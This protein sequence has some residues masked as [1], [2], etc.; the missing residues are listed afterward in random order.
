MLKHIN[1]LCQNHGTT[2]HVLERNKYYRCMKCRVE[3]VAKRRKKV[4]E[5]AAAYKGG[6]CKICGYNK[7]IE[8]LEFHHLNPDEKDFTIASGGKTVSWDTIKKEIDKCILLC[9]N[10]HRELHSGLITL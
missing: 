3:H 10:C 2:K 4:K 6:G 8:A 5:L 7:C 1:K 9:A